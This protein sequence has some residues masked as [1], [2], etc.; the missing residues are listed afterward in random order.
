MSYNYTDSHYRAKVEFI[1]ADDW[2]KELN[3]LFQDLLDSN[4]EIS[5]ECTNQESDAGVAYAKIRAV[6]PKKTKEEMANSSIERMLKDVS[7]ILGKTRNIDES[8]SLKFYK[9]LQ[10]FVD[11]KEKNTG[12]KDKKDSTPKEMEF[13]PLIKV[14]RVFVRAPALATG[15]VIVDLPGVHDA[16]AAR[17][18][19]AQGYMKQCTGLWIVAPIIRAV[20]DKAAKNLLGEHFRRQLKMD[21]G[22]SSVTFICSKT[23]D[24]SLTEASDSLGLNEQNEPLW[25]QIEQYTDA[26]KKLKNDLKDMKETK[27]TYGEI[28]ADADEQVEI[29]EELK[30]QLEEGKTVYA[31]SDRKKKRKKSSSSEERSSKRRKG[32]RDDDDDDF[33]DD[34]STSEHLTEKSDDEGG[35]ITGDEDVFSEQ[36]P[37]TEEDITTKINALRATKKESRRQRSDLENG[38]RDIKSNLAK[39]KEEEAKLEAEISRVCIE[40]R[41]AYSKGAIQQDFAAGMKELDQEMAEEEDE[42]NFNPENDLRDYNAVAASLPVFCVSSRGYQKLKGRLQKDAAVPGFTTVEETEMPQLRA[43]CK[44]LTVAGRTENC[45]RFMTNLSQL[46]NSLTLWATNDGSGANLT[47]EQRAKEAKFLEKSL[48]SLENVSKRPSHFISLKS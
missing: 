45:K 38:M 47:D 10:Q 2:E 41:N 25:K 15:A 30:S 26:Q 37:L 29:W 33:I 4:G 14:V 11:S 9:K 31:P 22:Y 32:P 46:L 39:A 27:E 7:H 44:Q 5:R 8:D 40:G 21:G 16:N 24:I 28:M 6:Y 42:A 23:D 34:G 35:D 17:A 19:V 13:W 1:T 18:A 36:A 48:D 43:H 20:D 12:K 3:I